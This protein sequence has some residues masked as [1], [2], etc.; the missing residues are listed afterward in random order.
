M[1]RHTILALSLCLILMLT[2][3]PLVAQDDE[4]P[5]QT[6]SRTPPEET[7]A[8]ENSPAEDDDQDFELFPDEAPDKSDDELRAEGRDPCALNE[9][10]NWIDWLNRTVTHSVCGSARWFDSFFGTQREFED[11]DS[12][13]GR[14]G[15]GAFWDE[16]DGIDPEFRFRA[17]WS[18]PNLENRV[19]IT[20]GRGTADEVL[21]GE[22]TTSP[23]EQFFDQ[24]QEWLVG[25]NYHL[26]IGSRSRL[27][28]S[29]GVTWSS[30]VDPY[31]RLR[32]VY[33][34]PIGERRQVRVRIIPQWQ[35]SK[36][37]GYTFFTS[38]ERTL[39]EK[40]LI[41]WDTS[42]KDFQERFDGFSYG[43]YFTLFQKVNLKNALKYRIGMV[44]QSQLPHQPQDAGGAIAWRTTVYKEIF[45]IESLIGT[46]WR[47]RPGE[48][49]REPELILGL[50]FELKFGQ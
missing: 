27:S 45:T 49:E 50:V 26:S 48:P 24:E 41:R 7:A 3:A 8:V 23:A 30:G 22:D 18:F 39:G 10:G 9:E 4:V 32:Y 36:G 17:K 28:P 34:R 37:F 2:G 31:V 1:L 42:M 40:F 19:Q 33:Q 21:E 12:T 11:R 44:S 47:R 29:V 43:L 20:L 25:F 5:G 38:L 46:T 13:F 14:L 16:D 35:E 15:V 6:G